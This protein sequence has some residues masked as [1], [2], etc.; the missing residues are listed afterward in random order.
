M[1]KIKQWIANK[2]TERLVRPDPFA[3]EPLP[4]KRM[5]LIDASAKL[6]LDDYVSN[7]D[8]GSS[9]FILCPPNSGSTA[10]SKFIASSSQVW[11]AWPN[12][13]GQW[14]PAVR[15]FMRPA[16]WKPELK[17][18]LY[19][20]RLLWLAVKPADKSIFLEKSP[21]NIQR[22]S[23]ISE[24]FPD[25]K[26]IILNRNPYAWVSSCYFRYHE[27]RGG[28][29]PDAILL[30]ANQWVDYAKTQIEAAASLGAARCLVTTYEDVVDN[31]V[32]AKDSILSFMPEL[33]HLDTDVTV[34]V[35]DYDAQ[36]LVN[37][38]DRQI[39]KLRSNELLIIR[40]V[41]ENNKDIV[42]HFGYDI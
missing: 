20:V 3:S 42:K 15:D 24:A 26:F 18:P 39:K 6:A 34:Q 27:Q 23:E 1:K 41:L 12:F 30:L 19:L 9:L 13:E 32:A 2:L 14:M 33:E 22:W 36:K 17:I 38:N 10:V 37:M 31:A 16:A 11:G 7:N 5:R 35:K 8:A 29:R 40:S 4:V 25:A 21:P 28:S